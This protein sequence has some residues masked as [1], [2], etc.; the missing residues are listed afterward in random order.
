MRFILYSKPDCSLCDRLETLVAPQLRALSQR[1]VLY[2]W[3]KR[4]IRANPDWLEAYGLRIPVLLAD[5]V[6][7]LEGRPEP[8][9]V[10][11][12]LGSIANK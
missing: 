6:V 7:L 10:A 12:A 5:G 9:D 4:D 8:R 2:Q 3:E 11:R 1:G